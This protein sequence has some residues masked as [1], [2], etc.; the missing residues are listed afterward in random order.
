MRS[1]VHTTTILL[2]ASA[3][4]SP[5]IAAPIGGQDQTDQLARLLDAHARWLGGSD[6]L[7]ARFSS[8]A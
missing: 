3:T 8:H 7:P 4:L 6:R 1:L 5:Q 2:L